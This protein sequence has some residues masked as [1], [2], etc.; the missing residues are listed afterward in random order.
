M[1][2]TNTGKAFFTE[3][4]I[5]K[6]TNGTQTTITESVLQEFGVFE[7]I[8]E[9]DFA[10]LSETAANERYTAF[11]TFLNNKYPG[12]D[13]DE[14]LTNEPVNENLTLCPV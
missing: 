8:T 4:E 7:E 3:I 11:K 6:D 14:I 9:D 12:L 10:L 13:V 2:V 1:A 5:V